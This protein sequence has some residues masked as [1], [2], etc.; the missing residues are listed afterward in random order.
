M[1]RVVRK[2]KNISEAPFHRRLGAFLIDFAVTIIIGLLAYMSLDAIFYTT[3]YGRTVSENF[4]QVKATSGLY[5]VVGEE[6]RLISFEQAITEGN[7]EEFYLTRVKEFYL[8]VN[9]PNSDE[10]L[11]TYRNSVYYRS[12][13]SFDFYVMVLGRGRDDTKFN[14][15]ETGDQIDIEFKPLISA[16]H[17]Q[18]EWTKIYNNAIKDLE[19]SQAYLDARL[20]H[21]NLLFIGG[22]SAIVVG[23]LMPSL[24][25]P[26]L[27]GHGQTLGKYITGLALVDSKGF[28]IRRSQVV[29]R[30]L[31]MGI[32]EL[33]ASLPLL[34][35]PLFITSAAVTVSRG[36]KAIHDFV[37]GT[38]VVDARQS[39]IF[40]NQRDEDK[41]FNEAT[42][43]S[44]KEK[45]QFYQ[46]PAKSNKARPTS[47]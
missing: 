36:A 32:L 11:F 16:D 14:F 37:A 10:K 18:L 41:Y 42:K 38:Y 46:M 47:R 20:P 29:I 28:K 25:I 26:L 4:H 39:L 8:D 45:I 40:D 17:R 15:N 6:Q 3:D 43:D 12:D 21:R 22:A 34:V 7:N 5:Y 31:V 44:V 13:S 27:F 33:G 35:I 1:T 9:R 23:G 24:V 30:Y 19:N 2:H